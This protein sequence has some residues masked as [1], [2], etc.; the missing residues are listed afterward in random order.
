M[1]ETAFKIPAVCNQVVESNRNENY[2]GRS[3]GSQQLVPCPYYRWFPP[4]RDSFKLNC[5]GSVQLSNG[6]AA[7]GGTLRD[8]NGVVIFSYARSP[9]GYLH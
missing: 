1:A 4:N 9:F 3:K 2:F 7:C 5:D 6:E 8:H